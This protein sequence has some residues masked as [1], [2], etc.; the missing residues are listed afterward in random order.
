MTMIKADTNYLNIDLSKAILSTKIL[1]YI[2]SNNMW[3]LPDIILF[4]KLIWP[5]FLLLTK[6]MN[7]C[8]LY[9]IFPSVKNV[10]QEAIWLYL[11]LTMMIQPIRCLCSSP[12]KPKLELRLLRHTVRECKKKISIEPL[13]LF[14]QVCIWS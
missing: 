6:R 3:Q 7:L 9:K 2:V 14:K 8:Y 1:S 10:Q 13:W 11:W 4:K 12:M 5:W